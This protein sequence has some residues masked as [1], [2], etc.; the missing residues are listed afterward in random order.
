MKPY[1][2]DAYVTLFLGDCR[3]LLPMVGRFDLLLTDPP[4][5]M[6]YQHGARKG[7]VLLGSDGESV[8]GDDEPFSPWH[9][10]NVAQRSILWGANHYASRLPDSR[11]WL[12][13][14][15]RGDE[16][17]SNDQ[18]DCELAWT[19]FLTT[20]RTFFRRWSGALRG[21]REQREGKLHS[22]QKPVALMAW[23]IGHAPGT[24]TLIDP[25]AGSG[26]SLVAAKDLG[27]RATGI[28]IS[29]RHCET[30]AQRLSQ[31]TLDLGA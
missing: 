29:E 11:G 12:V 19:D 27:I 20:A 4:Y 16:G 26:S 21:G 31:E 28:E 30:V 25:Y 2:E 9:L 17:L 7:G 18:S 3:E 1:Y 24:R 15:K 13:W 22:N 8:V 6:G 14:D 5:G 23:C 10:L